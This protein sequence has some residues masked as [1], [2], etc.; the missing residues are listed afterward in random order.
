MIKSETK[1][2]G[3]VRVST[4]MQE[5][6]PQ[7]Q[8]DEIQRWA[9]ANGYQIGDW[10]EDIGITGDSTDKRPGFQ[11]ML[12]A[13]VAGD[14]QTIICWNQDR[15]GRFDLIEAGSVIDPLRKA[16]V[17]LATVTDGHIGW[18]DPALQLAYMARQMSK[19]QFLIDHSK[20]VS[21]AQKQKAKSGKWPT[22]KPPYGYT[23]NEES[24]LIPD[25]ETAPH[26]VEMFEQYAGGC[27]LR[28]LSDWLFGRGVTGPRGGKWSLSGLQS[29]LRNKAYIGH[30]VDNTTTKSKYQNKVTKQTKLPESDWIVV[31]NTHEPIIEQKLFD[32]VQEAL[33]NNKRSTGPRKASG[34]YV[35]KGM[36]TCKHCGSV[37][38]GWSNPSTKR[39]EYICSNYSK[40]GEGCPRLVIDESE[41]LEM[42]LSELRHKL[43]S[44]I[45]PAPEL[46]GFDIRD[47]KQ[48]YAAMKAEVNRSDK[49]LAKLQGELA[50]L[51]VRLCEVD[52]DMVEIIQS[53]IRTVQ[54]QIA[55]ERTANTESPFDRWELDC[56]RWDALVET[57]CE[58]DKIKHEP[59][60][61]RAVLQGY[62]L[63][64]AVDVE[65][66]TSK[67]RSRCS[68]KSGEIRLVV[69]DISP[70]FMQLIAN[71]DWSG[72]DCQ[73]RQ[74]TP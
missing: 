63:T 59:K 33:T 22:G 64:V 39:K 18:D 46:E 62:G 50:R 74:L 34:D 25:G 3:Y 11:K 43:E 49:S 30:I 44:V 26:V 52:S 7:Q 4:D 24:K 40:T 21:R 9:D 36:V 47:N 27:S 2:V 8:R 71:K 56:R 28:E 45:P 20:N 23:V 73:T 35:L 70:A 67:Q 5:N 10:F 14:F 60:R 51:K 66:D 53:R 12:A 1:A 57:I 54:D 6:S 61:L 31:L 38:H 69:R 17:S 15:F 19:H 68:I 48:F 37:F 13:G 72:Q 65:R 42:I 58:L 16:G 32:A 29:L 41:V 55:A